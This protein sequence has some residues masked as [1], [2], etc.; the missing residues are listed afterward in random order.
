MLCWH[1]VLPEMNHNELVGWAGGDKRFSAI[2]IHTPEDLPPTIKR[3]E[4]TASI[5]Q[6]YTDIVVHLRPKG[7][8]RIENAYY[9]IHLGD[10]ISYYSAEDR[11]VD[12]I[13]IDVID[14]LKSELAKD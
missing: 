14:Y 12:P 3:M 4:L 1:H 7:V 8:N 11:A 9:L 2:M 10:W 6:K 13:E 5:I